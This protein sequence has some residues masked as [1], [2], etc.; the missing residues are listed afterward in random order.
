MI[1]SETLRRLEFDKVLNYVAKSS[2]SDATRSAIAAMAPVSDLAT[3]KLNWSRIEEIRMLARQRISLRISPF[4]DIRPLLEDVRPSG[5]ILAPAGLLEFLPVLESLA[6]LANQLSPRNDIEHL[7]S[8]EP[9]PVAF[10]DILEPLK[11]TLD[12][13]GNILDSA[14]NELFRIRKA[15]RTLAARVRKKLEEIVRKHETAIFLQDDFIT[16]RSGRWVIPVRM[17]SKGMVPGVVHDVSSS[18]ETAFM[19]PLEIIPFVNELENLSAEEKAE[20]IR[21]LRQISSWIREDSDR[22]S[23]CFRSLVELDRLESVATYAERFNMACPE[24]SSDR[25]MRIV[26]ARHPVLLAIEAE[27]NSGK[28]I[29]PLDLEIGGEHMVLAVSGPNAGGKTIAL[30]TLGLI[31]AMAMSGMPV[32]ASPSSAIPLFDTLLVDI[33]DEQSIESSLSTF[34]AHV[35]GIAE[36]LKQAGPSTLVLLD[37]LGTGTEP[38]QGAAIGCGVLNE[39]KQQGAIVIATTHLT[40]IVGFVQRTPGMLNAGMAFDNASWTPLYQLVMGEPGQSH[41]LETARRYGLPESVLAFAQNLLGTAGSAFA[42]IINELREKRNELDLRITALADKEQAASRREQELHQQAALLDQQRAKIVEQGRQQAR[43]LVSSAKREL[44]LLLD[45]FRKDR[46]QESAQK[47]RQRASELEVALS[48]PDQQPPDKGA[49]AIGCEVHVRSLGRDATVVQLHGDKVRVR[50]GNIELEVPLQGLALKQGKGT[51][52]KSNPKT[53]IAFSTS[54]AEEPDS[55]S[56]EL[57]L[58]GKRVDEAMAELYNFID[59]A[60]LTGRR[61]IRIVHGLGTGKLQQAVRELLERHPQVAGF[62]AGRPHEG[63]DGATIAELEH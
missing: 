21:I 12:S 59:Q 56:S 22:I 4:S 8:I 38:L 42:E 5:A 55:G 31:S 44:N 19:E 49:L 18:G 53:A 50:A 52:S 30:K 10:S 47:L 40:E 24:I 25:R 46:K 28:Q 51:S 9:F 60:V 58:I 34:S 37:E 27:S 7:K 14:S 6:G 16:I 54:V 39:L 43:D 11:A 15:K 48:P 35:S 3:L 17:D 26:S 13:E 1:N 2:H 36:I 23:A 29:Q 32:P 63:R 62:R 57:K 20:E 61:E 33:G 41:A 45:E